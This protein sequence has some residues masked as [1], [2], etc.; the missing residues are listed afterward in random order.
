MTLIGVYGDSRCGK[1]SVAN[2]LVEHLG[3]E[4]RNLADPIREALIAINPPL[5]MRDDIGVVV[6]PL[7]KFVEDWGWNTTKEDYPETVDWMIN[8]GQHMRTISPRIWLDACLAKPYSRLV[9]PDCRQPNE[10]DEIIRRGGVVWNVKRPGT[11]PRGMDRLLEDKH[12]DVTLY[13]SGT[14]EEL[15]SYVIK[16]GTWRIHVSEADQEDPDRYQD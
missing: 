4:K 15:T 12:F 14:I 13:N 2:I 11:V 9:I 5:V 6:N 16:C 8:L 7:Q 1:D 10:Y 3:F